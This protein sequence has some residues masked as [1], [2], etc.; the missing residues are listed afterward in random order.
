MSGADKL[1][2]GKLPEEIYEELFSTIS[3]IYTP[4]FCTKE[5]SSIKTNINIIPSL[6]RSCFDVEV[7]NKEDL[8]FWNATNEE[9]FILIE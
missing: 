6:L 9:E 3:Y 4:E 1:I 2:N 8:Q 7:E 5:L